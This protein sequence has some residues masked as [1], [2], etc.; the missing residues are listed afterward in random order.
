MRCEKEE[1]IQIV[2]LAMSAFITSFTGSAL[3]VAVPDI[4]AYFGV[5]SGRTG[6]I[7]TGYTL[8]V[9][10]LSEMCIQVQQPW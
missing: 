3:N 9:A 8:A 4:S 6:W 2:T 7:I 5:S 1:K 10:L